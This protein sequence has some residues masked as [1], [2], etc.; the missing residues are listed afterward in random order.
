MMVLSWLV[1]NT[2]QQQLHPLLINL[3]NKVSDWAR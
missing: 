1:A 3:W 2:Y